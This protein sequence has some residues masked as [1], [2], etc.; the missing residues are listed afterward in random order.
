MAG[1]ERLL[2]GVRCG[3]AGRDFEP[4][5]YLAVH[6]HHQRDAVFG[7]W[8]L[9]DLTRLRWSASRCPD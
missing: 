3:N 2:L 1:A 5:A 4:A 7:W 8:W 6:L 9:A